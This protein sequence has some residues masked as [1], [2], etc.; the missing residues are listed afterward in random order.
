M[1]RKILVAYNG[2]SESAAALHECILLAPGS[3]AEI[4][5]LVVMSPPPTIIGGEYAAAALLSIEEEMAE[6]TQKMGHELSRGHALLTKAGL[7]VI[8]HL[9]VGEPVDVISKLANQLGIELVI[10]GHS[11]HRSWAARWWRGS[12]NALLIEK[13]QC[14]LLVAMVEQHLS[15]K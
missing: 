6:A 9:E 13:M 10:V 5:L 2:T 15:H 8:N 12:T 7:N 1:Y 14:S 11:R 4:H 3:S